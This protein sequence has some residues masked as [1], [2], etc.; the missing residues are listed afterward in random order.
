[1][2][3][4]GCLQPRARANPAGRGGVC[5]AAAAAP[6]AGS[7]GRAAQIKSC[8]LP[9]TAQLGTD[10]VRL[11]GASTAAWSWVGR[12]PPVRGD[13]HGSPGQVPAFSIPV[14]PDA[15]HGIGDHPGA[16]SPPHRWVRLLLRRESCW[17]GDGDGGGGRKG[18]HELPCPQTLRQD[19]TPLCSP[20]CSAD[21]PALPRLPRPGRTEAARICGG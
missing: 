3:V 19:L 8:C 18:Q 14:F 17:G 11:P 16:P 15:K 10:G 5:T 9:S 6:L 4:P 7:S 21:P 12:C 1:M 20:F 2:G 13:A